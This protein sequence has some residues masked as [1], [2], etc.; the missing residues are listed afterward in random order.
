MDRRTILLVLVALIAMASTASA[1]VTSVNARSPLYVT[2]SPFATP[3]IDLNIQALTILISSIDTNW[4]TSWPVFDAN[5]NANFY[6]RDK[7]IIY[8]NIDDN[9]WFIKMANSSHPGNMI[10]EAPVDSSMIGGVIPSL[11][12]RSGGRLGDSAD[13]NI[14]LDTDRDSFGK[15][16]DFIVTGLKTNGFVKTRG[17]TGTF[18]VDENVDL[19]PNATFAGITPTTTTGDAN[20]YVSFNQMCSNLNWGHACTFYELSQIFVDGNFPSSGSGYIQNGPPGYISNSNDCGGW[21]NDSG[22]FLGPAWDFNSTGGSGTQSPCVV[23]L[24]VVCCR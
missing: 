6:Q 11:T 23:S 18:Y 9:D 1:F 8:S 21:K 24:P 7:N 16:G 19:N 3:T 20:G 13:G 15:T 10:I 4:Q 5:M 2:G 14:I 22:S 17:G 12:I